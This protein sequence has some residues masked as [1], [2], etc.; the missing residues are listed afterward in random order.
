[1]QQKLSRSSRPSISIARLPKKAL[2]RIQPN[3]VLVRQQ[4]RPVLKSTSRSNSKIVTLP[5]SLGKRKLMSNLRGLLWQLLHSLVTPET[6][7][8]TKNVALVSWDPVS[9][10]YGHKIVNVGVNPKNLKSIGQQEWPPKKPII[11]ESYF[12]NPSDAPLILTEMPKASEIN[13]RQAKI[14]T[15]PKALKVV[16]KPQAMTLRRPLIVGQKQCKAKGVR[17]TAL[18][19]WCSINCRA[20]NCPPN[21]CVCVVVDNLPRPQNIITPSSS[22]LKIRKSPT[23]IQSG[24]LRRGSIMS[25]VGSPKSRL[26]TQRHL[27]SVKRQLKPTKRTLVKPQRGMAAPLRC[28]S[29]GHFAKNKNMGEWCSNNCSKGFCP[30]NICVCLR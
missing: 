17:Q 28:K 15:A 16:R 1:M 3:T 11:V 13:V 21:L 4:K 22:Q 25:L 23:P 2:G 18:N 6:Q 30:P 24:I 9:N 19:D 14:V 26:L 8:D 29:I 10:Q 27:N 5:R 12:K 7:K 20:G